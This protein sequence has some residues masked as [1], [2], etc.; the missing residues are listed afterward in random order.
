[1]VDTLTLSENIRTYRKEYSNLELEFR[2]HLGEKKGQ[3]VV[4]VYIY[5]Y[6]LKILNIIFFIKD[7]FLV[8]LSNSKV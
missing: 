5:K 2:V 1:M 6:I 3:D 4:Q 8:F 7:K